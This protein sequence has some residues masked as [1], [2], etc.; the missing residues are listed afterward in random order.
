MKQSIH[1]VLPAYNEAANLPQLFTRIEAFTSQMV[2]FEIK[3]FIINDGSQDNTLKIV[4]TIP[5]NFEKVIIDIQPNQGLANAIRI[6]IQYGIKDLADKGIIVTMDADDSH[7]PALIQKM[8]EKIE[9][10]NELVIASRF[11]EGAKVVG[12][13]NF[14]KFMS[15]IASI[16]FRFFVPIEGVRDYTCGFRAYQAKILKD[17]M[18]K[19]QDRFIEEK[20]F[21]CMAE[22]LIKLGKEPIQITEVPMIL[23]YDRKKSTSKMQLNRTIIKS[24]RLLFLHARIAR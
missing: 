11:C 7:D 6:G 12:L 4:Q 23:H 13:S 10:G 1:I 19:Y 9:K 18:D 5:T 20:G 3:A 8:V 24:L 2:N 17:A 16:L 21:A 22:I 14:R 15:W